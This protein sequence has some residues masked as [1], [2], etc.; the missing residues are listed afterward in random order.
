MGKYYKDVFILFNMVVG[1]VS[2]IPG[3]I[4]ELGKLGLLLQALGVVVIA[5]I[6]FQII[7]LII[8]RKRMKEIY[9]IKK[10]MKRIEGKIDKILSRR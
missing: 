4:L 9:T 6:I 1:D 8:N 2:D 7:S 5:W 10:D 3:I